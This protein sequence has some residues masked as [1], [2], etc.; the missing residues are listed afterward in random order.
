MSLLSLYPQL[1]LAHVTLVLVSGSVFTAR[2]L[3]VLAGG[4][5][6]Q[7]AL[8]RWLVLGTAFWDTLLL[9]F[10]VALWAALDLDPRRDLWLGIK[11]VLLLVYIVTGALALKRAPGLRAKQW[12]L[13]LALLTYLTMVSVA[14]SHDPAG[15]WRFL[16]R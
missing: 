12:C 15:M 11:L 13:A 14:L 16:V 5:W 7:R 9:G 3:A 4:V 10:G 2:A 1:K 6:A 8:A